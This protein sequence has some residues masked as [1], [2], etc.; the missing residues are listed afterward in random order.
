VN[1]ALVRLLDAASDADVEKLAALRAATHG[2][3][4]DDELVTEL[5]GWLRTEGLHRRTWLAE[6]DEAAV[7]YVS[8]LLY[9]RMPSAVRPASGWAYLG[10]LFVHPDHRGE[11]TGAALVDAVVSW[12]RDLHLVRVVLSPS[13]L[14]VPLYQRMG[15]R[16]ADELLV[17][18]LD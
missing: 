1:V 18:P 16:D 2:R 13:E 15:F 12:A 17:L 3:E 14:S 9:W 11:G 10:N 5:K 7:G 4:P 6:D 8:A